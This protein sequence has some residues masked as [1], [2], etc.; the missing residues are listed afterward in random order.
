[1]HR[2]L[3]RT[4]LAAAVLVLLC[5]A[6]VY[7][8]PES[9]SG[10]GLAV[11]LEDTKALTASP[12]AIRCEIESVEEDGIQRLLSDCDHHAVLPVSFEAAREVLSDLEGAV[13]CFYNVKA[14]Y[15]VDAG[16]PGLFRH[17][18]ASYDFLGIGQSYA[19]VEE[20][21]VPVDSAD[22]Y[23]IRSVLEDSIDNKLNRYEGCWYIRR[24]PDA[25]DGTPRTYARL[26][27]Q[28]DYN[29]PFFLQDLI[30]NLFAG[31]EVNSMFDEVRKTSLDRMKKAADGR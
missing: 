23:M 10:R 24:L 7:A 30:L 11:A 1:M 27:S 25:P 6:G 26:S 2:I 3:T 15:M 17:I 20:V 19:Y 31:F 21:L 5:G 16:R 29:D 28:I 8:Q 9:G 22:E 4:K 12:S 13:D 18:D 14:S